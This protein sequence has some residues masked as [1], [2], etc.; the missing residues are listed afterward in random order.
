[1]SSDEMLGL[2]KLYRMVPAAITIAPRM[3]AKSRPT[4]T[5]NIP[6]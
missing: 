6:Y 4:A 1:V 2:M 3:P 5:T